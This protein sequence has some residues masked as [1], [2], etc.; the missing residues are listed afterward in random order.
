MDTIYELQKKIEAARHRLDMIVAQPGGLAHCYEASRELD[1]LIEIYIE[2]NE[3][4][5]T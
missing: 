3:Q 5:G 2:R 4:V 1:K